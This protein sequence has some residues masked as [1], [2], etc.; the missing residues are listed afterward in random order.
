M[1]SKIFNVFTLIKTN[2]KLIDLNQ[3]KNLVEKPSWTKIINWASI[4]ICQPIPVGPGAKVLS[5]IGLI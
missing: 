4:K 2:S 3:V 5:K 1:L